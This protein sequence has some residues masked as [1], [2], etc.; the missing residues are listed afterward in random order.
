M[1]IGYKKLIPNAQARVTNSLLL[2]EK[3]SLLN[4][5]LFCFR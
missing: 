4:S 2:Y 5:R 1:N 3:K